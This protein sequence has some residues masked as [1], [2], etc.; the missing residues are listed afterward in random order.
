VGTVMSRLARARAN[1]R[2][3]MGL[4]RTCSVNSLYEEPDHP[5]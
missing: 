1:L 5:W 2:Q 4:S 3:E